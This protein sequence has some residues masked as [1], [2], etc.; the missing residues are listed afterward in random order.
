M[1]LQDSAWT[2]VLLVA[3]AETTPVSEAAALQADL[4]RAGIEPFAWVINR[5]LA[6][7]DTADPVLAARARAEMVQIERVRDGLAR[8]LAVVP[9][10][11]D[12]PVGQAAL[13]RLAGGQPEAVTKPS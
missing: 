6:A 1:R 2:H 13:S 5:S 12:P 7:T 3:L 9:W 11:P 8:R 4:R 10:E